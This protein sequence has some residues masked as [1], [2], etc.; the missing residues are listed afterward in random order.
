M[1]TVEKRACV[2]CLA[3]ITANWLMAPLAWRLLRGKRRS[4][5]QS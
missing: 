1:I 5:Q 3:A 4:D 2:Y